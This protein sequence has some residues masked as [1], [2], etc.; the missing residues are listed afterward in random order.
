V[1]EDWQDRQGGERAT[2][3]ASWIDSGKVF[4]EPDDSPVRPEWISERF[5]ELV[6]KNHAI[7]K[8]H[9]KDKTIEQLIR[10]HRVSE[11][12]VKVALSDRCR[13]S[14]SMTCVT[15]RR[16]CSSAST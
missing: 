13:P 8:G 16:P 5:D 12:A 4:T 6:E 15:V 7:H 14:A 3:G 10:R 11:A 2:A 1:L 9:T